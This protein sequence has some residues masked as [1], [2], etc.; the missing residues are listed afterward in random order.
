[1]MLLIKILIKNV[2]EKKFYENLIKIELF[3]YYKI[4]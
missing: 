1:M 2:K 3:A 4:E